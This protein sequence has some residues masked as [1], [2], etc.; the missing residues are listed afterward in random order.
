VIGDEPLHLGL[1]NFGIAKVQEVR[2][3]GSELVIGDAL[4]P[5]T[6]CDCFTGPS[7]RDS[8]L[9][10]LIAKLAEKC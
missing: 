1:M 6:M 2:R 7:A 8:R 5:S 3:S 9:R 4:N 10:E